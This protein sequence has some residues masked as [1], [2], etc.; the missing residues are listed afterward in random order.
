MVIDWEWLVMRTYNFLKPKATSPLIL[1]SR[2]VFFQKKYDGIS[3]ETFIDDDGEISIVGRGILKGRDSD[4]TRKF[5]E[6]VLDIKKLKL[7]GQT[8][9]LSETI[10]I[11]QKTGNE[12]CK[13]ATGR[14]GRET[15]IEEY[16]RRYPAFMVIH[17]V[18]SVGGQNLCKNQYLNRLD[19]IR[20]LISNS[21]HLSVIECYRDG[22]AE[23][24]KV[25]KL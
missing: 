14:S 4:F 23:W 25:K 19:S 10:V 13:L 8:D 24:E 15:D 6:L 2:N 17:D 21:S 16:S 9:F 20:K 5:P 22:I 11:D 1:R 7:P 12:D 18:V 3:A